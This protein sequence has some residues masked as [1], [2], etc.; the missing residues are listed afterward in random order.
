MLPNSSSPEV[1]ASKIF[2]RRNSPSC[3]HRFW[4]E[5][6]DR[7]FPTATITGSHSYDWKFTNPL[8]IWLGFLNH[9]K[10]HIDRA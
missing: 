4:H 3:R 2:N 10:I 6:S 1:M 9:Q 7:C 5:P 8:S